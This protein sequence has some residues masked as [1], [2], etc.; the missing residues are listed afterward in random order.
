MSFPEVRKKA[1]RNDAAIRVYINFLKKS[2]NTA[3]SDISAEERNQEI[4]VQ[5]R[6]MNVL[7]HALCE[8]E[9]ITE[10]LNEIEEYDPES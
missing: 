4:D 3:R 6:E 9:Q 10:E 1:Y 7:I 5:E 2:N 8:T